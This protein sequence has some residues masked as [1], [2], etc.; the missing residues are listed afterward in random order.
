[1]SVNTTDACQEAMLARMASSELASR[2][3]STAIRQQL[4]ALLETLAR[5]E[6]RARLPSGRVLHAE[7]REV[8][9]CLEHE[10]GVIST[11]LR[12]SLAVLADGRHAA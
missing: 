1:M 8:A 9:P 7:L 5:G 3:I 11:V 12:T 6:P 10:H 4:E 2:W